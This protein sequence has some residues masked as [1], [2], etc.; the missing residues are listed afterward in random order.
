MHHGPIEPSDKLQRARQT[1]QC[2]GTG[3]DASVVGDLDSSFEKPWGHKRTGRAGMLEET[4]PG[5]RHAGI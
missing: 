4:H 1:P 5:Y 2:L 3:V